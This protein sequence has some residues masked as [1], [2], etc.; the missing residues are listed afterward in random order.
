[1]LDTKGIFDAGKKI[2]GEIAED[3]IEQGKEKVK[4]AASEKLGELTNGILSNNSAC[5]SAKTGDFEI[6]SENELDDAQYLDGDKFESNLHS[7]L[8]S[9]ADGLA[10]K[11]PLEA[12]NVLNN[13][14]SMATDVTKFTETQKTKRKEIEAKKDIIVSKIQ[15][16]KE[17]ILEY[18]SRSF[19]ER[20]DNFAKF[21]AI[22]DDAIAKNN[23]QQLAMGL[24]S[25]NK[26]AASSPFKALANIQE[27]K[28]ALEDKSHVWDF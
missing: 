8:N 25:I 6:E 27:T 18:L 19:D 24:D 1:M 13:F 20:K 26:L 23:M 17:I 16:D 14:I 9:M 3:L 22:V 15:S 11:N 28:N 7:R 5:V 10:A 21:F 4:S 2:I 12:V